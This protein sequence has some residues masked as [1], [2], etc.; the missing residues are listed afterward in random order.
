MDNFLDIKILENLHDK[1]NSTPIF[2]SDEIEKRNWNLFCAVLDSLYSAVNFINAHS[3]VPK[4]EEDFIFLLIFIC[5]VKD[6]IIELFKSLHISY[7][8]DKDSHF[9]RDICLNKPL[10]IP[11]ELMPS[12]DKF[13]EYF[14][15][16]SFAHPFDTDR[17][18]FFQENEKQYSP[19]VLTGINMKND[20]IGV[21]AYS[22][23]HNNI[24][25][26]ILPFQLLKDYIKS[27]YILLTLITNKIEDIISTKELFWRKRKINRALQPIE[28]L[29]DASAILDIRYEEHYQIDTAICY[30]ETKL[31]R[32]DNQN[33][34]ATFRKA[35]IS[36]IPLICDCIDNLEYT[37][38]N[39]NLDGIINI[40][41]RNIYPN[42]SYDLEKIYCYLKHTETINNQ[43]WGKQRAKSF[44]KQFAKKWVKINLDKMSYDEIKLLVAT[45]CYLETHKDLPPNSY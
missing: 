40:W 12:D 8:F 29:R 45:A 36:Q 22:N 30:L 9:F 20:E 13:F 14:R 33:P 35:I 24:I 1:I 38:M 32:L 43:N 2:S 18:K 4:K 44:Y 41:P 23:K 39:S 11:T 42:S 21:R 16:L 26:I 7:P 19:F 17:P 34:V 6:A 31:T 3:D 28:I 10:E 5:I 27:R 25:D 37:K 15:S